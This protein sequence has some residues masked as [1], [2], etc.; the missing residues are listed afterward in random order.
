MRLLLQ[1]G[2]DPAA[3]GDRSG[4]AALHRAA[5]RNRASVLRALLAAGAD[6]WQRS[7]A[8]QTPLMY[9][10]QFGHE[11]AV[12]LLLHHLAAAEQQ[13]GG[14]GGGSAAEQGA[15][16]PRSLHRHLAL[17]DLEGLSALHL[18]A[19]WGMAGAAQLLLAAGAGALVGGWDGM[20]W[21]E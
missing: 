5:A 2:A 4:M 7:A 6:C 3:A 16:P 8:G 1:L 9:A 20:G 12:E 15:G 13:R 21:A 11:P 17:C 10:S 14:G 19:R 18:A